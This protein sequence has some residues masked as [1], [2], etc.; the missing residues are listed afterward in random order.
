MRT[1]LVARL[2]LK[3]F[4]QR[5]YPTIIKMLHRTAA[6]TDEVVTMGR[7][8]TVAMALVEAMNTLEDVEIAEQAY[9]TE[10]ARNTWR[11]TTLN[12]PLF[13][14]L[15]TERTQLRSGSF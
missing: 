10:D 15:D 12:Q 2:P 11:L 4:D 14:L 6:R 5:L 1:D 8:D 7:A 13:K 3:L 9:R